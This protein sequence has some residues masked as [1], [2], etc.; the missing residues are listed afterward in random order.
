MLEEGTDLEAREISR[1]TPTIPG[2]QRE[3]RDNEPEQHRLEDLY[4]RHWGPVT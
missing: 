3:A 1:S 2:E 4:P